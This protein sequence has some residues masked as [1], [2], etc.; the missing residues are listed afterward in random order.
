M[1]LG[2]TLT[3]IALILRSDEYQ[4]LKKENEVNGSFVVN[5][6]KST[7]PIFFFFFC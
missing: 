7:E 2:K 6:V 4:K 1:G 3:M 5:D